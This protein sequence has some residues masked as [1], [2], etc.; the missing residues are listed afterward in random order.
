MRGDIPIWFVFCGSFAARQTIVQLSHAFHN[1]VVF[2]H[3]GFLVLRDQ[4][5]I[6]FF[7][8]TT[9]QRIGVIRFIID[10]CRHAFANP[11]PAYAKAAQTKHRLPTSEICGGRS[12]RV[13][14]GTVT[15]SIEHLSSIPTICHSVL[16]ADV[17]LVFLFLSAA[18]LAPE[19]V[20]R[21][22]PIVCLS[23]P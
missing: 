19:T 21:S 13:D 10:H 14:T 20:T 11:V 3:L 9:I 12:D 5:H 4:L 15:H 17:V 22:F 18:I 1:G 16:H 2:C 23:V 8:Q 7:H 6:S